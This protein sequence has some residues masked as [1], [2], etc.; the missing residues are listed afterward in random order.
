MEVKTKDRKLVDNGFDV[1]IRFD[2]SHGRIKYDRNSP[3]FLEKGIRRWIKKEL[4]L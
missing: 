2:N 4:G 1:C 3:E